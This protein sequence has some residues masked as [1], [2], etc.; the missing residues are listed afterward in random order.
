ME[1]NPG[2]L[3]KMLMGMPGERV[4]F[5]FQSNQLTNMSC[6]MQ[7]AVFLCFVDKHNVAGTWYML[8][9]DVCAE[10]TSTCL[11]GNINPQVK[12]ALPKYAAGLLP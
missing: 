3:R 4:F 12:N 10:W 2:V 8:N 9:K 11:E 1:K 7:A 5:F 6:S